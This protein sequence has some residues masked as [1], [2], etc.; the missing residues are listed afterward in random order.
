M[1]KPVEDIPY[2][3]IEEKIISDLEPDVYTNELLAWLSSS[4]SRMEY[5]DEILFDEI[6]YFKKEDRN[7]SNLLMYGQS[8]EMEEVYNIGFQF[9]RWFLEN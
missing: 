1:D 5:I 4:L 3:E 7:L 9:I 6:E 8:K 2:D